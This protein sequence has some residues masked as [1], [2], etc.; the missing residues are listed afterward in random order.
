LEGIQFVSGDSPF[1]LQSFK[2]WTE[3][4][5]AGSRVPEWQLLRLTNSH[6]VI[7]SRELC[8]APCAEADGLRLLASQDV[9][10][11]ARILE[12]QR[13]ASPSARRLYLYRVLFPL[14]RAFLLTRAQPVGTGRQA[15]QE[16]NVPDFDAGKTLLIPTAVRLSSPDDNAG[17]TADVTGYAPGFVQ[18]HT[19]SDRLSYL[20]LSEVN[21]PGWQATIDGQPANVLL[22]DGLFSALD[23]PRGD[24]QVV[25]QYVPKPFYIGAAISAATLLGLAV[26]WASALIRKPA[27]VDARQ[28][29][30][31][32]A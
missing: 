13:S 24:H 31:G 28:L 6:Y 7:S 11:E 23:M 3:D 4:E 14:P 16:L 5:P 10:A 22:A 15:I 26:A 18:L 21:Y 19:I 30:T 29:E 17:L 20:Y 32:L 1:E 27:P 25:L 2:D 8:A 12:S 9:P